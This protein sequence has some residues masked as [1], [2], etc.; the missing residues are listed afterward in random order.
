VCAKC[1]EG[2][3][4]S[5]ATYVIHD[6]EPES[7]KTL[8]SFASYYYAYWFM[9]ILLVGTLAFFVPHAVMVGV[10]EL[11]GEKKVPAAETEEVPTAPLPEIAKAEAEEEPEEPTVEVEQKDEERAAE[12]PDQKTEGTKDEH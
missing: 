8:K 5:Y 6:P 2:A 1:H 9:I 10:R 12:E 4:I 3:N 7:P 11:F